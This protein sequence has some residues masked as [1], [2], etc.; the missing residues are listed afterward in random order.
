[1]PEYINKYELLYK[2]Q[3]LK[4]NQ[5]C[6]VLLDDK[7]NIRCDGLESVKSI[8]QSMPT[9]I[10]TSSSCRCMEHT[11]C[12]NIFDCDIDVTSFAQVI[13]V[14]FCWVSKKAWRFYWTAFV[15]ALIACNCILGMLSVITKIAK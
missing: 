1:M 10:I 13:I 4:N 7:N 5:S 15:A 2:I 9:E 3:V 12:D 11:V 8:I 14:F 6:L